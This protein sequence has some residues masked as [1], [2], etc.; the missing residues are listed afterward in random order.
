[1]ILKIQKQNQIILNQNDEKNFKIKQNSS[2]IKNQFANYNA[3]IIDNLWNYAKFAGFKT[4]NEKENNSIVYK[5]NP[6]ENF[7]KIA[8]PQC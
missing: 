1:M 4:M 5:I 7:L 3:N 2:F 8:N 6:N